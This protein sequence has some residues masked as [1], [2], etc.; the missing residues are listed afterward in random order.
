MRYYIV[1]SEKG[2]KVVEVAAGAWHE[3]E[4]MHFDVIVAMAR[5]LA[6]AW[7]ILNVYRAG[8]L[9]PNPGLKV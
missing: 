3:W 4:K 6:V 8:E 7:M 2:Y 9:D 5:S 1:M